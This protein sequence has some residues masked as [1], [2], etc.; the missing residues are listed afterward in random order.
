MGQNYPNTLIRCLPAVRG[1]RVTVKALLP[2]LNRGLNVTM[3]L[4][5][6]IVAATIWLG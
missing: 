6:L 4:A 2:V 1:A 3:A 5:A